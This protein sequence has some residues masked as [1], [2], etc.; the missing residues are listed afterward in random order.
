MKKLLSKISFAFIYV[1]SVP[2][3]LLL[4]IVMSFLGKFS[5]AKLPEYYV[6]IQMGDEKLL[7]QIKTTCIISS[8]ITYM[9][10][11]YLIYG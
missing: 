7:N 2:I 6:Q 11:A 3:L 1:P 8:F 4:I 10:T 9:L 5:L